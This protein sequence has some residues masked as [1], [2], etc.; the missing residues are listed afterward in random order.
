VERPAAEKKPTSC[1]DWCRSARE[2]M[3]VAA[4]EKYIAGKE[5]KDESKKKDNKD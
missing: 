3:G 4:Y 2:C 1:Y 5:K